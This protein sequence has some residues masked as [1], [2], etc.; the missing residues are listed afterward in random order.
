MQRHG[1]WAGKLF[2]VFLLL[3]G[4]LGVTACPRSKSTAPRRCMAAYEQCEL[5][6]GPLGVCQEVACSAGQLAPC[7][8]CVSQH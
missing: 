3:L 2:L 1:S 5:P 8:N 4:G 6:E 7:F